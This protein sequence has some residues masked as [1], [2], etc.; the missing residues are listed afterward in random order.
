MIKR[1]NEKLLK[2]NTKIII[3]T[4]NPKFCDY[5]LYY[6]ET[7][8]IGYGW[9]VENDDVDVSFMSSQVPGNKGVIPWR[10]DLFET[11]EFNFELS[12]EV[13][14]IDLLN[15]FQFAISDN[16]YWFSV[17]VGYLEV[18]FTC[19]PL[20]NIKI[21]EEY[22]KLYIVEEYKNEVPSLNFLK[23]DFVRL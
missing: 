3:N 22:I 18:G 12:A 23:E 10:F 20:N 15:L 8:L 14:F 1:I 5:L 13:N 9:R 11:G 16:S 19:N 21:F 17:P 6:E 2:L 7:N 4:I